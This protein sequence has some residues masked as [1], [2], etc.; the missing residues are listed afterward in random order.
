MAKSEGSYLLI[1]YIHI[2]DES[3]AF[4]LCMISNGHNL[5]SSLVVLALQNNKQK[6]GPIQNDMEQ[7][8]P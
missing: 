7:I 4:I 2:K 3:G 8:C 5:F 1:S 6:H